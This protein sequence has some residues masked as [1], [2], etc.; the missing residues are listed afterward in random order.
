MATQNTVI[1]ELTVA[2]LK[3]LQTVL[4]REV[5]I[6]KFGAEWCG[7]CKTIAP[8]YKNFICKAPANII[9]ADIDIDENMDIYV[10]LK[11]QKM[12]NGIPVFLAFFGGV[13]RDAWF[14]PD[15][16]VVGANETMVEDFFKR[17]TLKAA[18]LNAKL[19]E[20]GYTYYT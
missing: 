17:C 2:N 20:S 12:V 4:K 8:A 15:D 10:A 3:A 1:T 18:E 11:K 7:P 6:I 9:F 16:S 14:I 5:L 19:T 13:N